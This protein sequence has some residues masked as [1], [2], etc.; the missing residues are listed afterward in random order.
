MARRKTV[1]R[2]GIARIDGIPYHDAWVGYICVN[3]HKLNYEQIGRQLLTP[4]NALESAVWVCR[5][6]GFVHSSDSDLPFE[7]WGSDYILADSKPAYQFWKAFFTIATE[8]P[9]SYWKQCNACARILPF[10][11]FSGHAGW[12]P[13]QRQMECRS[14]KG[15]I[16]ADLNPKRTK[17]QLHEST[18][19]R[20]VADL[21]VEE[22][23]EVIDIV[24]LFARF[25]SRCFKTKEPLD[26]NDRENWAI[27]HI[28]PS[29]YLYPLTRE[30][31]A[32]LS[33]KA[34]ENKRDS[35]PS[36]FYNNIELIELARITGADIGLIS[37]RHPVMNR[38]IDVNAG[39]ERYLQVRQQSDLPK[40]IHELRKILMAY[41]LIPNL[42]KKNKKLLGL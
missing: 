2:T 13:L 38:N 40:R 17:Q 21:F 9:E 19:R 8:Q 23:N 39:V 4:D 22:I 31:A 7:D 3:C 16:N 30:N 28:L 29:R 10:K 42:S 32:L 6:C 36:R 24:D 11:A 12:G 26:I 27:D 34:N 33:R 14:C 5:N 1:N 18:I 15:A 35:W 20:R 41:E 37:S 25:G